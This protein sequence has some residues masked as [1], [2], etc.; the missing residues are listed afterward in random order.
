MRPFRL[1]GRDFVYLVAT[2]TCLALAIVWGLFHRDLY[3]QWCVGY[4][5]PS[6]HARFGFRA[7][8]ITV[9]HVHSYQP[10][11]ILEVVPDGPLSRAGFRAGDIPVDHHGGET[12]FCGAL[13]R[14]EEGRASDVRVI[15]ASDW[16]HGWT[17][18]R[19]LTIPSLER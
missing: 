3:H 11:A 12:A 2:L 8:R 17:A 7:E 10:L 1:G 16:H 9:P 4:Y 5:I 18:R 19:D 15:N 13:Q 14:A 6:V